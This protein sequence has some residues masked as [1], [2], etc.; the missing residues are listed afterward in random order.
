MSETVQI[1]TANGRA[2]KLTKSR[3]GKAESLPI[4]KIKS[5]CMNDKARC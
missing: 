2:K 3:L 5:D 1:P 4:S